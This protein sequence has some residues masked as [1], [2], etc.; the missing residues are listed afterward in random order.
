MSA[1]SP[2]PEAAYS[3]PA[4]A[5]AYPASEASYPAPAP[6]SPPSAPAYPAT[7]T[8]ASAAAPTYNP[9]PPAAAYPEVAPTVAPVPAYPLPAPTATPAA[10]PAYPNAAS[11]SET[12]ST[13]PNWIVKVPPKFEESMQQRNETIRISFV[14]HNHPASLYGAPEVNIKPAVDSNGQETMKI[15]FIEEKP[16]VALPE[17][18]EQV[19]LPTP[20][21]NEENV[22]VNLRG[23]ENE[24][25]QV[26]HPNTGPENETYP[27]LPTENVHVSF[28]GPQN[29]S[30]TNYF[31]EPN[32]VRNI[33]VAFTGHE[34][35]TVTVPLPNTTAALPERNISVNFNGN[36]AY[37]MPVGQGG[38]NIVEQI[39][40]VSPSSRNISISFRERNN[41][42]VTVE[43]TRKYQYPNN[44]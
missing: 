39:M 41:G 21:G 29:E 10:A 27:G 17:G 3:A 15:S 28:L 25:F 7:P 36:H 33:S 8:S 12:S 19:K 26:Y 37:S 44:F 16:S 42:Q 40:N 32:A 34:N 20:T 1:P 43:K 35:E 2:A 11:A 30:F 9:A 22:R 24:T 38:K 31:N 23:P 4:P 6:A 13:G 14:K 18:V 5:A